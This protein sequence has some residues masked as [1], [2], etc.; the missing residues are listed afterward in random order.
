MDRGRRRLA[1]LFLGLLVV[2]VLWPAV[3]GAISC[4]GGDCCDGER[5]RTCGVAT[6]GF[7]LCCLHS[8]STLPDLPPSGPAPAASG[9]LAA[10]DEHG[11]PSPD[12]P[13]ILH[14]PKAFFS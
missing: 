13:G 12:L 4:G 14:V 10:D 7:S 8:V 11:G 2:G 3:A 1:W 9:L 6:S 5:S